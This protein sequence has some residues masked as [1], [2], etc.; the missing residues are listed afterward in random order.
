VEQGG[1]VDLVIELREAAAPAYRVLDTPR[2]IVIQV[3]LPRPTG[4]SAASSPEAA[5]RTSETR[6]IES[7]ATTDD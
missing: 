1:G 4:S 2:G 5:T 7:K 3:D 6:R